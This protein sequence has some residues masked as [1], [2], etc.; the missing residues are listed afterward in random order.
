MFRT[1]P[2]SLDFQLR[3]EDVDAVNPRRERQ[4]SITRLRAPS[5]AANTVLG[6]VAS[7]CN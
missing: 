4:D 2:L 7:G 1:N 3:V 5:A 6:I